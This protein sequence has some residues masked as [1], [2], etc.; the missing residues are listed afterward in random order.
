MCIRRG[1]LLEVLISDFGVS[2]PSVEHH[3][4]MFVYER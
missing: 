4:T 1:L 3:L 2:V